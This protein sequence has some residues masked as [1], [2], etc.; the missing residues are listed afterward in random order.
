M[1]AIR[2]EWE[3]RVRRELVPKLEQTA[4]VVSLVPGGEPDVKYA[5]ELGL[6]IM[7]DKPILLVVQPGLRVPPKLALIADGIIEG[8]MRTDAGRTQLAAEVQA[9]MAR[10]F[11]SDS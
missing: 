4:C 9:F 7:L 3:E 5:V 11:G 8:D 1:T 2:D 10:Q 6:S